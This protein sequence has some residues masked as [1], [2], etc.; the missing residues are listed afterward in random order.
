V[1]IGYIQWFH[2]NGYG[3][4]AE[5]ILKP[6]DNIR[7][8]DAIL[9]YDAVGRPVEPEWPAAEVI[10]AKTGGFLDDLVRQCALRLQN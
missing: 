9:A 1:W 3:F 5:P 10:I 8:M 2:A 6:L 7:H 4:P